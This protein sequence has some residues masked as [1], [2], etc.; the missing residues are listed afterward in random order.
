MSK[1]RTALAIGTMLLACGVGARCF[2]DT[3]TFVAVM[4]GSSETPP[5]GS[6]ATGSAIVTLNGDILTVNEAF[7]GLTTAA[8]A[9][10]IHCCQPPGMSAPVV[11]PFSGFPAG[12][13]GSFSATFD[14][15][16]FSFSGG[17]NEA[18]FIAGL[19]SGMAYVNI[20]NPTFPSGEI[21]GQ[22]DLAPEPGSLLLLGTSALGAFSLLRSRR[23]T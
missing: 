13:S 5:N 12:T 6:T 2:A 23:Q 9:A 19:E 16:T 11:V 3:L 18:T 1:V 7:S 15:S 10:H 4:K 21:R 22:L 8:N 14:L 17:I 20:H